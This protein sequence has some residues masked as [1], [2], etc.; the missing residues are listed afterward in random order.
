MAIRSLVDRRCEPED[1]DGCVVYS[2]ATYAMERSGDRVSRCHG[3]EMA[4]EY[5]GCQS[6]AV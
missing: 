3:K 4:Y 1:G 6:E 2:P 5:P